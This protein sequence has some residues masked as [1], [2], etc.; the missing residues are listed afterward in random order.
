MYLRSVL[1]ALVLFL[2]ACL[3]F[4]GGAD[5]QLRVDGNDIHV[6]GVLGAGTGEKLF[7]LLA[8]NPGVDRLV[9]DVIDGSED[10]EAI[11][12]VLHKIREMGLATH[13]TENSEIYSG[14]V[15]LFISGAERTME[16]GAIIGVH[17]WSDGTKS[18]HEYPGDH[19][20]HKM[21]ADLTQEMLGSADWYWF[22]IQSAPAEGMHIMTE[23]EIEKFGM[24]TAPIIRN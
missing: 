15:D 9:L 23:T 8:E 22:T 5:T 12:P 21:F 14:G 1:C 19:A 4:G 20:S 18:A 17:S 7:A 10:D 24:L 16:A 3:P 13:L 6:S 2:S 11:N